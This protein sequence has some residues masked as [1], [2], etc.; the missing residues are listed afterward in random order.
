MALYLLQ[1]RYLRLVR[2]NEAVFPSEVVINIHFGPL[3]AFGVESS[4]G[5]TT[6]RQGAPAHLIWN[7]NNS[8]SSWEGPLIDKLDIGLQ[9]GALNA[10]W[11]GNKLEMRIRVEDRSEFDSAVASS[12]QIL[13]ILL[14]LKLKVYVWIEEYTIDVGATCY[15]YES[16]SHRYGITIASTEGRESAVCQVIKD[17]LGQND[18]SIRILMS[19][20][21]LRQALR[22]SRLEPDRQL[23][24]A[25][26]ILNLAKAIEMLFSSDRNALRKKSHEWG[27]ES[28]FIEQW[29]VPI[30][31]IRN[32]LDVAHVTSAANLN[33]D[34]RAILDFMDRACTKVNELVSR[35]LDMY[36][37]GKV[38][39]D[40]PTKAIDNQRRKLLDKI[41]AYASTP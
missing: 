8:T 17:W 14:S 34:H 10:S 3:D 25:E 13:P 41:A 40:P 37:S 38:T 30:L 2:G 36:F 5:R 35:V 11:T 21:Y 33:T 6:A 26:V 32:E 18:D 23:M 39:L 28:K 15:R 7:A 29:I 19:A 9:F 12:S 22:L 4:S 27:I 24:A 16:A 31:L 20:N 1:Q